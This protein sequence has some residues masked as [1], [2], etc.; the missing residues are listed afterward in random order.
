MQRAA[1]AVAAR[2]AFPVTRAH[3]AR[4]L[5]RVRGHPRTWA[6]APTPVVPAPRFT[7]APVEA[8]E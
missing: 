7:A 5:K 4:F 3:S 8:G 2:V 1:G 6:P